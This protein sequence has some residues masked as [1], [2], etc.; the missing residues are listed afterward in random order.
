MILTDEVN[1]F[2]SNKV[3]GY[4]RDLGYDIIP[5]S[6]NCIKVKD[7]LKKSM[8]R[9]DVK[10][11]ICG[12]EKNI[13]YQKYNKNIQKYN[14]YTCNSSCAQFKNRLTLEML[15]GS[16]NFNRSVE[17]KLKTK[18]KYDKIT[19]EIEDRGYINCIKCQNDRGLSEFLVKNERYKH[20]CRIC[21]N[22]QSYINRNKAPH[23][24]AWRSVLRGFLQRNKIKKS[25][26][27][28]ELLKYTP[29]DLKIHI[30]NLFTEGMTW[31]NYGTW[32]IDHIVHLTLFKNDTPAHIV[33]ELFNLRPLNS[34]LNISRHNNMDSDCLKLMMRYKTYIKEEYIK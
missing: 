6:L 2:V 26:K 33:N 3:I 27:T 18:E 28:I 11:D 34:K 25:S 17:N 15:Y 4:Y 7:L 23:I 9:I 14:I 8:V 19:R 10:C 24:K 21:R 22:Q 1:I 29:E 20:I 5:N 16:Q 13:N 30:E 12:L 31:D 32:H